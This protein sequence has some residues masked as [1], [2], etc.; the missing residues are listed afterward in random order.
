MWWLPAASRW[1]ALRQRGRAPPLPPAE[2]ASGGSAAKTAA[3][4]RLQRTFGRRNLLLAG[5]TPLGQRFLHGD[6]DAAASDSDGRGA[7]L[8]EDPS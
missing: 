1:R 6:G 3:P 5:A 8:D 4:P 2:Q 7:A